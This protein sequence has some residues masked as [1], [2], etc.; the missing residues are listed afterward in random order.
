MLPNSRENPSPFQ[1]FNPLGGQLPS[2]TAP[3]K[4]VK[5]KANSVNEKMLLS[6]GFWEKNPETTLNGHLKVP[7]QS[8]AA[9]V[10]LGGADIRFTSL[11][12]FLVQRYHKPVSFLV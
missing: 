9:A 10:G 3:R 2:L 1:F 5:R 8:L 6:T 11:F 4:Q 12:W 7:L